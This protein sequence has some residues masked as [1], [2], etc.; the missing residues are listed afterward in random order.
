MRVL[1]PW[2]VRLVFPFIIIIIIII[3]TI[4]IIIDICVCMCV[5]VCL[6]VCLCVCILIT[7]DLIID[8]RNLLF[9]LLLL[10]SFFCVFV[11][12]RLRKKKV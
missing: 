12:I 4:I 11:K 7:A 2:R 1:I 9:L 5:C 3:I 6:R 10:N 8:L